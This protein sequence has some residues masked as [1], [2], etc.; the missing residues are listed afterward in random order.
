MK[1]L[2]VLPDPVNHPPPSPPLHTRRLINARAICPFCGYGMY[3]DRLGTRLLCVD[4]T[5]C[6]GVLSVEQLPNLH[7]DRISQKA[8]A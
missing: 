5:V 6:A 3:L 4:S 8:V 2:A 1:N 7:S